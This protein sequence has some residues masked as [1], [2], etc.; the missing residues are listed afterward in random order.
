[1]AYMCQHAISPILSNIK[2]LILFQY[3]AF[4][5]LDSYISERDVHI[6]SFV[7]ICAMNGPMTVLFGF[8]V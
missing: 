2:N 7:F 4:L 5:R 6:S 1:M 3:Q 8:L